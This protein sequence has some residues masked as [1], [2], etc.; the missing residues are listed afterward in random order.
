MKKVTLCTLSFLAFS[1]FGFSQAPIKEAIDKKGKE[2]IK[3]TIDKIVGPYAGNKDGHGMNPYLTSEK[4]IPDT[5]AL[6]TFYVYDKGTTEYH[7][8]YLTTYSLSGKGGNYFANKFHQEA[9]G[10]LKETFKSQGIVLLTPDEYLNTEEKRNFYYKQ[11]Q[12][13]ISKFGSFISGLES[14]G[15]DMAVCADYYRGFDEAAAGDFK[16][17]IS[18]GNELAK[19]LGVKAVLSIALELADDGK[20]ININGIKWTMNGPNP[21]T[22]ED[23][24]Y[25]GTN[26]AG[27]QE[28]LV[29]FKSNFFFDDGIRFAKHKKNVLEEE[30]YEGLGEL[31]SYFAEVS[32]EKMKWSIEK[33]TK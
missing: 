29:Y 21:V 6:I 20:N 32:V 31:L 24:K 11:F 10:K 9:I 26:G 3:K 7:Q 5:V 30:H 15:T 18:L 13:Q 22:K 23:K 12:P 8:L 28:G 27:Y 4:Q 19:K 16:R 14:G 2:K 1:L 17:S 25:F 33:N